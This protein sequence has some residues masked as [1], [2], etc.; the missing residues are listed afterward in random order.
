[1]LINWPTKF[2]P[3]LQNNLGANIWQEKSF[4]E[5]IANFRY[6]RILHILQNNTVTKV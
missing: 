1:M 3:L 2:R 5:E 4:L 6:R